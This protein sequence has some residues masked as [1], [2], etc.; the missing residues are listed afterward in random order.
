MFTRQ[1]F[2]HYPSTGAV[3]LLHTRW[4]PWTR[5][6]PLTLVQFFKRSTSL[7]FIWEAIL[8][9]RRRIWLQVR[10]VLLSYYIHNSLNSNI[11]LPHI[12]RL[13]QTSWMTYEHRAKRCLSC[14]GV[15]WHLWSVIPSFLSFLPFT[16]I[17]SEYLGQS[18]DWSYCTCQGS[19]SFREQSPSNRFCNILWISITS[20]I[21]CYL[22]MVKVK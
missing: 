1:T 21:K 15:Q 2:H 18:V 10:N 17:L 8:Q 19:C 9:M 22:D 16:T 3:F 12:N 5:P 7:T 11:F 20:M 6:W 14:P 4:C 13:S